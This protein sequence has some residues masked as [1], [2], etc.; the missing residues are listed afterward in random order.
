MKLGYVHKYN[1]LGVTVYDKLLFDE[2]IDYEIDNITPSL[3]RAAI[4]APW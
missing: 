4:A 3:P 2:F 1:Y